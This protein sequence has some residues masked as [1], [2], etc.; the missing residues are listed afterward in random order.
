MI[1]KDEVLEMRVIGKHRKG[2]LG[3]KKVRM[4]SV[5][6]PWDFA[7]FRH[8]ISLTEGKSYIL[9]CMDKQCIAVLHLFNHTGELPIEEE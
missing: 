9:E 8:E 7:S 3:L 4:G 6:C 5:P 1:K 2:C